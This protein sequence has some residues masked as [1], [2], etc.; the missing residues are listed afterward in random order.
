LPA[1]PT[2]FTSPDSETVSVWPNPKHKSNNQPAAA[3]GPQTSEQA[4]SVWPNPAHPIATAA[5]PS[6]PSR[7][8]EEQ[9]M[10][11]R[12]PEYNRNRY[13]GT[14]PSVH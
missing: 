6:G 4:A 8:A 10:A 11:N 7:P 1:T 12:P 14:R 13:D 5:N 2:S 9:N 3:S